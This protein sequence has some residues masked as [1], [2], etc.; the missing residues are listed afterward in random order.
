VEET[1][2]ACSEK[3]W[4][5]QKRTILF[6][7]ESG[8]YLLPHVVRTWSRRGRRP[9]LQ[10][11]GSRRKEHLSA[12]AGVTLAGKGN[13]CKMYMLCRWQPFDSGGVIEF[14]KQLMWCIRGKL[15]IIWDGASI[16]RSEQ[17]RTFLRQAGR[18]RIELVR[19]PPYAPEL[20]PVEGVWSLLKGWYLRNLP[21]QD[22]Y[23]L[24]NL[25][26]NSAMAIASQ[27]DRIRAC[28]G[29]AGCY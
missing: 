2:V 8:F 11:C 24:N 22:L 25:L 21:C 14:L 16:H 27:P 29:Q 20:N 7:D 3:K 12:I 18:G 26:T 28:F 1:G 15:G 6:V 4:L 5:R 10:D 17:V 19:L 13:P 9:L 23:Q